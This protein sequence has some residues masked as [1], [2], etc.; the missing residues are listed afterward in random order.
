MYNLVILEDNWDYYFSVFDQKGNEIWNDKGE[1]AYLTEKLKVFKFPI[2]FVLHKD[3][4][5]LA[6]VQ[7]LDD[8]DLLTKCEKIFGFDLVK[9]S[10]PIAN[11]SKTGFG[12]ARLVHRNFVS[13][14]K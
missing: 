11:E 6:A 14:V 10:E 12:L 13:S 5:S 4:L 8:S 9:L 3:L 2:Q 7:Y 1:L